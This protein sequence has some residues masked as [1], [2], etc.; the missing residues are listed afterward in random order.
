VVADEV[1]AAT[2][3]SERRGQ[4]TFLLSWK[5]PAA[6][7]GV[8][9][10]ALAGQRLELSKTDFQSGVPFDFAETVSRWGQSLL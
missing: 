2:E 5:L 9:C 6:L 8:L 4:P 1:E 7:P 10:V 3:S